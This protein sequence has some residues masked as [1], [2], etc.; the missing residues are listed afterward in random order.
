M[1]GMVVG[2]GGRSSGVLLYMCRQCEPCIDGVAVLDTNVCRSSSIGFQ[3]ARDT[4]RARCEIIYVTKF[5]QRCVVL[6][7][8]NYGVVMQRLSLPVPPCQ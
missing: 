1:G 6:C 8:Y 3:T 7:A 4:F 2:E 5:V